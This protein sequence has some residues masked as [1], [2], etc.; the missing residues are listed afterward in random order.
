VKTTRARARAR[1]ARARARRARTTRA[2]TTI[3]KTAILTGLLHSVQSNM[4]TS[5][6]LTRLL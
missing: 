5:I 2:R 6:K 1:R 3:K 4:V